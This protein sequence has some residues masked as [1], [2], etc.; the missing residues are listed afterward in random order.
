MNIIFI[1]SS[2]GSGYRKWLVWR[3]GIKSPFFKFYCKYKYVLFPKGTAGRLHVGV[4]LGRR[5]R[6][7]VKIFK[8]LKYITDFIQL[9]AI[10]GTFFINN[11]RSS[12]LLVFITS[13]NLVFFIKQVGKIIPPL[14]SYYV[15][16]VHDRFFF[17]EN[18]FIFSF[19]RFFKINDRISFIQSKTSTKL[20]YS[21]STGSFSKLISFNFFK[22]LWQ[23]KLAS[24]TIIFLSYFL[25][26]LLV[27][28]QYKHFFNFKQWRVFKAGHL[29]LIGKKP[30]V[31]G[32]AKNPIDHPHGG[33]TN[34]VGSPRT[35]WGFIAKKNK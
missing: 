24:G 14:F 12:I 28:Q 20:I 35:P 17:H 3:L 19:L 10:L 15:S 34:T 13:S 27:P 16:W 33:R 18:F 5:R 30:T 9:P 25:K 31:R 7:N 32:I 22:K 29:K 23:I 2:C 21:R 6:S 4:R 11:I 8:T 1:N 26:A